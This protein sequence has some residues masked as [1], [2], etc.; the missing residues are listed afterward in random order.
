MEIDKLRKDIVRLESMLVHAQIKLDSS[1]NDVD[2]LEKAKV[3][4]T[5]RLPSS[6]LTRLKG[7]ADTQIK[8]L[9]DAKQKLEGQLAVAERSVTQAKAEAQ[10]L[11]ND[12]NKRST[13]HEER[14]KSLEKEKKDL[15]ASLSSTKQ[16]FSDE[17]VCLHCQL[18]G[19]LISLT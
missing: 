8:T 3:K 2:G 4:Q 6:S 13:S 15:T 14:I 18:E 16:L 9:L 17:Q 12:A 1:A 5:L 7:Y 11:V 19:R 10:A